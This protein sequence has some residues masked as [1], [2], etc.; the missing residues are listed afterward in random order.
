MITFYNESRE[1]RTPKYYILH[2]HKQRLLSSVFSSKKYWEKNK[3]LDTILGHKYLAGEL[4][5]FIRP[6]QI[7]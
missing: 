4:S 5:D 1:G 7:V 2:T 3:E 6:Y